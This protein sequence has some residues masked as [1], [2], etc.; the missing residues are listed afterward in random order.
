MYRSSPTALVSALLLSGW[1]LGSFAGVG[2]HSSTFAAE[3]KVARDRPGA[4]GPDGGVAPPLEAQSPERTQAPPR[5]TEEACVDAWL[6]AQKLDPYGNPAGTMYLGGTP[7]FDE[8]TGETT[9]RLTY[10]Y[11]RQPK[12][13]TACQR[14]PRKAP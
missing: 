11:Q 12:A 10:V 13:K 8:R 3:K 9:D 14:P 1:L 6:E 7:L 5:A 2:C 4:P